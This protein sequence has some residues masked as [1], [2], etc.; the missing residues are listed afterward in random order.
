MSIVILRLSVSAECGE[1][2]EWMK[3]PS[4]TLTMMSAS[5]R[6]INRRDHFLAKRDDRG[7]RDAGGRTHDRVDI[8]REE[9]DEDV[10]GNNRE[11][12]ATNCV[13]AF[14]ISRTESPSA[15]TKREL[16]P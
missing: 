16:A 3:D 11:D 9:A 12:S 14:S 7:R 8:D 2:A 6:F 5:R 10:R 13:S 4:T 1:C 15:R